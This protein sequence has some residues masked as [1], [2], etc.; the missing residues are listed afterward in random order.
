MVSIDFPVV[1]LI[2]VE[3]VSADY[4]DDAAYEL[5]FT[6]TTPTVEDESETDEH[7]SAYSDENDED[8]L[9]TTPPPN[10]YHLPP[11]LNKHDK[12]TMKAHF[13]RLKHQ[14]EDGTVPPYLQLIINAA[15]EKGRGLELEDDLEFY[16]NSFQAIFNT[17]VVG[18]NCDEMKKEIKTDIKNGTLHDDQVKQ[19]FDWMM[20]DLKQK[21]RDEMDF[22]IFEAF[23][24]DEED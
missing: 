7:D 13:E 3:L 17:K 24:E 12:Q 9:N 5:G 2:T 10:P 18:Q 4:Y 6:T 21:F 22:Q 16:E 1:L 23:E 15:I 14:I 20:Y 19:I 8:Y 11:G